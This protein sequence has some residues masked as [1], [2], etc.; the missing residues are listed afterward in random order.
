MDALS[1]TD[2]YSCYAVINGFNLRFM[3][4]DKTNP[5]KPWADVPRIIDKFDD[6]LTSLIADTDLSGQEIYDL[7]LERIE[8]AYNYFSEPTKKTAELKSLIKKFE[9]KPLDVKDIFFTS[10]TPIAFYDDK[11]VN[12]LNSTYDTIKNYLEEEDKAKE[13]QALVELKERLEESFI[14]NSG[15]HFDSDQKI[16]VVGQHSYSIVREC[17][18]EEF[19]MDI[20][21]YPINIK[22]QPEPID[23][24]RT[25]GIPSQLLVRM[26]NDKLNPNIIRHATS[27]TFSLYGKYIKDMWEQEKL[28]LSVPYASLV[29]YSKKHEVLSSKILIDSKNICTL[30]DLIECCDEWIDKTVAAILSRSTQFDPKIKD[31]IDYHLKMLKA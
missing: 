5:S 16:R 19:D 21:K 12:K 9:S 10:E 14:D 7:I 11:I 8:D 20:L 28:F 30:F 26:W 1:L 13:E 24:D 18:Q 4:T 2:L 25:L 15:F 29:Q 3:T 22:L 27:F 6:V 17:F 23:G 31:I